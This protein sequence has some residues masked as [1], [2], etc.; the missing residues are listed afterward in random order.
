MKFGTWTQE[1]VE[2]ALNKINHHYEVL[3]S[4]RDISNSISN[5]L[6][7]KYLNVNEEKKNSFR[8]FHRKVL[9]EENFFNYTC[10]YN[11][12][13]VHAYRN[14]EYIKK[15]EV[16]LEE[17]E[18]KVHQELIH[19]AFKQ[20]LNKQIKKFRERL[21]FCIGGDISDDEIYLLCDMEELT[22]SNESV[23]K[24]YNARENGTTVSDIMNAYTG[25]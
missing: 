21:T 13:G 6:Y 24:Y 22:K 4:L 8:I 3:E 7:R 1:A 5:N 10:A 14:N 9:S 20:E 19:V 2:K 16:L 18:L 25:D 17:H 12:D 23:I 15:Y 11:F